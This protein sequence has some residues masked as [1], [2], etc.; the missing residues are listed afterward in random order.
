MTPPGQN[1][2]VPGNGTVNV[3]IP[4]GEDTVVGEACNETAP[5]GSVVYQGN[6]EIVVEQGPTWLVELLYA[7]PDW[8]SWLLNALVLGTFLLVAYLVW[9]IDVEDSEALIA[10][11]AENFFVIGSIAGGTA[12]LTYGASLPYWIDVFGGSALGF[13]CSQAILLGLPRVLPGESEAMATGSKD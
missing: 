10:D 4:C 2:T 1:E 9:S 11:V 13:A 8:V 6:H 12:V 7:S 3:D 5:N